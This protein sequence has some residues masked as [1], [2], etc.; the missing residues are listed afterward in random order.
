MYDFIYR[1]AIDTYE[2]MNGRIRVT[3]VEVPAA[4]A[5]RPPW[6]SLLRRWL[7]GSLAAADGALGRRR[8]EPGTALD[9]RS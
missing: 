4:R 6:L 2:R 8:V 1:T 5:T 3:P 9:A 7:I